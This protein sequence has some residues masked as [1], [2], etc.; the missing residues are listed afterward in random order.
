[1]PAWNDVEAKS[2]LLTTAKKEVDEKSQ[3]LTVFKVV[4]PNDVVRL[5]THEQVML[6]M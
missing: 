3:I 5:E 6:E 1:M 2:L 4:S